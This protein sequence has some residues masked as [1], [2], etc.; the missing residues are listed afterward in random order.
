M[1]EEV[2]LPTGSDRL[3][4][5]GDTIHADNGKYKL[6]T[7]SASRVDRRLQPLG[8]GGYGTVFATKDEKNRQD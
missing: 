8:D 6:G 5:V 2:T 1:T 7:V 4:Q 3:P